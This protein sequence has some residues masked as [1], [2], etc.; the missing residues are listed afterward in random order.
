MPNESRPSFPLVHPQRRIWFGELMYPGTG[1]ANITMTYRLDCRPDAALL[2][3]AVRSLV[4]RHDGL[5]LEIVDTGGAGDMFARLEQRARPAESMPVAIVDARAW[6]DE[7][8]RRWADA[9]AVVPFRLLESPLAEFS[10]LDCRDGAVLVAKLHHVLSDGRTAVVVGQEIRDY[11]ERRLA[12]KPG[13]DPDAPPLPSYFSFVEPEQRYLASPEAEAQ[14]HAWLE[15]FETLPEPGEFPPP[16]VRD[17]G[18]AC[19]RLALDVPAALTRATAAFCQERKTSPFKV[20]LAAAAVHFARVMGTTDLVFGMAHHGRRAESL[21]IAGMF[22]DTVPVRVRVDL[23]GTFADVVTAVSASMKRDL[24][25]ARPYPYDLLVEDLRARHPGFGGLFNVNVV[26]VSLPGLDR[27]RREF[28]FPAAGPD[29]LSLQVNLLA[30][31]CA[32]LERLAVDTQ[33]SRFT[34]AETAA[35]GERMLALI[36]DALARPDVPLRTLAVMPAVERTLVLETFNTTRQDLVASDATVISLFA[37]RVAQQPEAL[38]LVAGDEQLT[39]AELDRQSTVL[40]RKLR[41]L[42]VGADTVVG[43]LTSRTAD[44][45]RAPLSVLKAGGAYVPMDPAYPSDRLRYFL[46]NSSA[47]VLLAEPDLIQKVEG[48]EGAI[49]RLGDPGLYVDDDTDGSWD[50]GLAPREPLPLPKPSDLAYVIYT[51]GSTGKPKGV[52]V[53]HRSLSNFAASIGSYYGLVPADRVTH[54]FGFSFDAAVWTTM[55]PLVAGATIVVV[56]EAIRPSPRQLHDFFEAN[57]ITVVGLPTQL[58]EQFLALPP[59]R[60][61]RVVY[62]GGDRFRQYHETPYRVVNEYGPTENTVSSTRYDVTGPS[63]NIPIGRP[64]PNTRTYVLDASLEPL[65]VGAVGELCVAGAQVARGYLGR[66]D[67][68]DERFVA[69]PFVPGDRMYR[70]G[71]L[72]RWKADGNIEFIGRRDAQVKIRGYRIETGEIEQVLV[73]HPAVADAAVVARVDE[74]GFGYLC[75]YV[76]TRA[77]VTDD[78]IRAY[79]GQEL[80]DY[81]VPSFL[82]RMPSLPLTPNGKVDRKALPA[83]ETGAGRT[84][85]YAPPGTPVEEKLIAIWESVLGVRPIGI[86]ENFFTLGGH[87]LKAALV[88]ARIADEL[89][90]TVPLAE[91]FRLPS[92]AQLAPAVAALAVSTTPTIQSGPPQERTPLAPAQA[93]LFA[94]GQLGD[95]GTAYNI[96]IANLIHGDIDADRFEAALRLVVGRHDAFKVAF[97]DDGGQ[98]VMVRHADV[99]FALERLERGADADPQSVARS[100][101]APFD[102]SRA[103]LARA[104]LVRLGPGKSLFLFEAHHLVFDGVSAVHLFEEL[105]AAYAGRELPPVKLSYLDF[106]AWEK[107]QAA[108]PRRDAQRAFWL[109]QLGGSLPVLELPTDRPRP[110]EK[111]Y[112]GARLRV[113]SDEPLMRGLEGLASS[114]GATLHQLLLSAF[115]TWLFRHGASDDVVIGTPVAGRLQPGLEH[116]IGMFVNTLPLRVRPEADKTFRALV[117]ETR[118]LAVAALDRQEVPFRE[119]VSHLK[120]VRDPGRNPLYDV[121]FAWQNA[122][123]ASFEGPGFRMES[124]LLETGTAQLDLSLDASPKDGRLELVFEYSTALFREETIRRWAEHL[125]VLLASVVRNPDTTVASLEML[126][127]VELAGLLEGDVPSEPGPGASAAAYEL[128]ADTLHGA[129]RQVAWLFPARPALTFRELELDYATLDR[130]TDRLAARLVQ[131]GLAPGR[132]G[133]LLFQRNAGFVVAALAVMKAG[134]AYL[135]IDPDYPSDRIA[136]LLEDSGAAVLLTEPSLDPRAPGFAGERLHVTVERLLDELAAAPDSE[137]FAETATAADAAYVIY[138]SGS[139]G[140]PKGVVIEHRNILNLCAWHHA[141]HGVTEFDKSAAYSGFGFDASVWEIFPFLVRG[142]EVRVLPEDIRLSIDELNDTFIRGGITITNL[143]TQ[144][145]EQFVESIES[146]SLRTLVTGGDALRRFRPR[147]Y[148]LVN[149]YGPTECTIS[150]TACVVTPEM[151]SGGSI[152]IGRPLRKTWAYVVGPGGS[153]QPDGVPGELCL[154]GA[155][156]ARGYLGRPELTAERFIENPFS[157]GP[158][159]TRLYRTGDRVRRLP[160]RNIEYLGRLDQQVKIRGFRIELGEIEQRVLAH[161]SVSSAVVLDVDDGRGGKAL[162]AYCVTRGDWDEESLREHIGQTLPA[163]M[164]PASFVRLDAIPLTPN[165]KIDRRALPAPAPRSLEDGARF[166]APRGEREVQLASAFRHVLGTREPGALDDFFSLG[167][168]SI[169]AIR[170]ASHLLSL[171]VK[172][173]VRDLFKHPTIRAL[174]PLLTAAG[175]ARAMATDESGKEAPLAPIQRWLFS[176][177]PSAQGRVDQS[178]WLVARQGLDDE[179]TRRAL[180]AVVAHHDALR[181]VFAEGPSGMVQRVRPAGEGTL[182]DFVV[183]AI[184]TDDEMPKQ[185]AAVADQLHARADLAKGPL[186]RAALVHAPG[187][188]HLVIVIHHLVVDGVS[189]RILTEDL[190]TAYLALDGARATSGDGAGVAFPAKTWSFAAWARALVVAATDG[191]LLAEVPYWSRVEGLDVPALP[192]DAPVPA[193]ERTA[194]FASR[195]SVTLPASD[196]APLLTTAHAAY[197]TRVNDLLLSGLALAVRRWASVDRVALQMEG[198]GREAVVPG[199]DISRTVGWFTSVFPLVLDTSRADADDIGRIVRTVKE[200]LRRLPRNGVGAGILRDLTPGDRKPGLVH[201]LVPS[202]G[203]NYLGQF[204]EASRA[205][206]DGAPF[207]IAALTVGQDVGPDLPAEVPIDIGAHVLGGALTIGFTYDSR[208][209]LTPSIERFAQAFLDA[210][211]DVAAHCAA[212]TTPVRT[213]SDVGDASL[214]EEELAALGPLDEVE[215][216]YALAPMQEGM[217]LSALR[218]PSSSAYFEQSY[219]RVLGPLEP[220]RLREALARTIE[221]HAA[222]RTVVVTRGLDRPRQVVRRRMTSVLDLVDVSGASSLE[223]EKALRETAAADVARGFDLETGPLARLTVLRVGPSEHDVILSLHHIIVDG[224]C[225]GLLGRELFGDLA[226]LHGVGGVCAAGAAVIAPGAAPAYRNYVDWVARQDRPAAT[227]YWTDLLSGYE[228]R[229]GIPR[230]RS[231]RD[232]A[233]RVLTT[234]HAELPASLVTGLTHLA[235][236]RHATLGALL[237]A[238]WGLLLMRYADTEDAV[239][240]SV[241][242]GRPPDLPG[243]DQTIGLFINTVPVRVAGAA[244]LPFE[245]LLSRVQDQIVKSERQAFVPLAD[246]QSCSDLGNGLFEHILAFESF[247]GGGDDASGPFSVEVVGGYDYSESDFAVILAPGDTLK[248]RIVY[249]AAVHDRRVVE[250]IPGHLRRVLESVSS[251]PDVPLREIDLLTP[252]ERTL[253]LTR[254]SIGKLGAI[255]AGRKTNVRQLRAVLPQ[256]R[257]V[258][259]ADDEDDAVIDFTPAQYAEEALAQVLGLTSPADE[260]CAVLIDGS[261]DLA[262]LGGAIDALCVRHDMLRARVTDAGVTVEARPRW[263][264]VLRNAD[265]STVE[266][267]VAA[268]REASARQGSGDDTRGGAI[269]LVRLGGDR[270]LLL[271][272]VSPLLVDTTSFEIL[273]SELAVLLNGEGLSDPVRFGDYASWL[274]D[275]LTSGTLSEDRLYWLG[276][277]STPASSPDLPLDRPRPVSRRGLTASVPVPLADEA[278]RALSGTSG[279]VAGMGS[280]A[281]QDLFLSSLAAVLAAHGRRTDIRLGL[282]LD[283]RVLAGLERAVGRFETTLPLRLLIDLDGDALA[284][285]DGISAARHEATAHAAYPTELLA[286][287]LA[288]PVVPGRGPLFDVVL[289]VEDVEQAVLVGPDVDRARSEGSS[290][291]RRQAVLRRVPVLPQVARADLTLRVQTGSDGVAASLEYSLDVF[292]AA[293]I[294]ALAG[295]VARAVAWMVSERGVNVR[296]LV[297][298]IRHEPPESVDGGVHP[299][300]IEHTVHSLVRGQ[301]RRFAERVAV[302]CGDTRLTYRELDERTDRL[303]ARLRAEGVGRGQFVA[304]MVRRSVDHIIGTLAVIKAGGAFLPLD[305]EYPDERIRMM[306]EDSGTRVFLGQAPLRSRTSWF[307]GTWLDLADPAWGSGPV[308]DVPDLNA[309]GDLAYVI[310][311]SG[312]TGKPKGAMISH[313]NLANICVDYATFYELGFADRV[314]LYVGLGFD[315]S[316]LGIF[317]P[318]VAGAEVVV[319]PSELRLSPDEL[320]RAFEANGVTHATLPT[321]FCEQFVATVDCPTL[322]TIE[323]GGEALRTYRPRSYKLVNAYGPTEAT[324]ESTRFVVDRQYDSIPIG[325]PVANT[326]LHVVDRYRRLQPPGIPGELCIAG[327]GLGQGYLGRPELTAEKFVPNPWT[328]R[329]MNR[330]MYRTGDLVRWLPDGQLEFL[331]RIDQQVKIRGFRIELGEIEQRLL[332]Q[333]SVGEALVQALDEPRGGKELCAWV[334]PRDP[335]QPPEPATIRTALGR[336]LPDYMVPPSILVLPSFPVT[337]NGKVDRKALPRPARV[338]TTFAPPQGEDEKAIAAVFSEVLGVP[339]VGRDDSFFAL[340]GHSIKAVAATAAVAAPVRRVGQRPVRASDGRWSRGRAGAARRVAGGA[341]GVAART[342]GRIGR[343]RRLDRRGGQTGGP[344]G[345]R[346]GDARGR[347]DRPFGE[348]GVA[349][350]AVDRRHRASRNPSSGSAATVR[351]GRV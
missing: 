70:T 329:E 328:D 124:M 18:I 220:E 188:D 152:P 230:I 266:Q 269:E 214:S 303:A 235:R 86:H 340:G 210:L 28:H 347:G 103:P 284:L 145:A 107:E 187:G 24:S 31:K 41:D 134:A 76:V 10:V 93:G 293:T 122:G 43:I 330:L 227:R 167:G 302:S 14:R 321:Q 200:T 42:G 202:I 97:A 75:G 312:S 160:D 6:D 216:V 50:D 183:V 250:A 149:E 155:Q 212:V 348:G 144:L 213:G 322:R 115:A 90:V 190:A 241:V 111:G 25:D 77:V 165:G 208:E 306:V 89:G 243:A 47:P 310:Y 249:D 199:A 283:G 108:A 313:R 174:A 2:A 135:P 5:R 264:R 215:A 120:V 1:F 110:K 338:A 334:T 257:A 277:H 128:T 113:V 80:P 186:V 324:V 246:I 67:L 296:E 197:G 173:D 147:P 58:A 280:A 219:Y 74:R 92:V 91:M 252:E 178:T 46:S 132:I 273:V 193:N 299:E 290:R 263:R 98:P 171:G 101:V 301:A 137:P 211:R 142:C 35:L 258:D 94:L 218:T 15:R 327:A 39:Y 195:F 291:S 179:R 325:R 204:D 201:R 45:V 346:L 52:M 20:V 51:S 150:A 56:P 189:W 289:A 259:A 9:Q 33:I 229:V 305:P 100:L 78:A 88:Q 73:R 130:I 247:P 158:E 4:T 139:T 232:G 11:C 185:L 69:D 182:V 126:P 81:M 209:M 239:F 83:P 342:A 8:V 116:V 22:V 288:I 66:P 223:R 181:L 34:E 316:I 278:V 267:L 265:G 311:T 253:L 146:T 140:R 271:L 168:D 156:V 180:E 262:R 166:E 314:A 238:A 141:F 335:N 207:H 104:T 318:L 237:H 170:L 72:A 71:D 57:A 233:E 304:V 99:K 23:D 82:T 95:L 153:L 131:Q 226:A 326:W 177:P 244:D 68:T 191:E 297:A 16:A 12:G 319:V 275:A 136:F 231:Q 96:P 300:R 117:A 274:D 285:M 222:L 54:F 242:S 85:A 198:H 350:R 49:L 245:A 254:F 194:A 248:V 133:A 298:A 13:V 332:E 176:L 64:N 114:L 331:G 268:F 309:P 112:E 333:E 63:E 256:R 295:D 236:S 276:L 154:A 205:P 282:R 102:L 344:I 29:P 175:A 17:T 127:A 87:S 317:P 336:H 121:L 161:P 106:A 138:T 55:P 320:G 44:I 21:P 37:E 323:T 281:T 59:C 261:V 192:V 169:Q 225:M 151:A 164:V 228:T 129:F 240:G 307:E 36:G 287:D 308:P 260:V 125:L 196:T 221:R 351:S 105:A 62:M 32:G 251:Q 217:L 337:A 343:G 349:A 38:A 157:T 118:D 26:D 270:S 315:A 65:P 255:H 206:D 294:A 203:F 84:V 292:D 48:Y 61:V 143:P 163:Y 30:G 27:M 53:E 3:E 7:E 279:S 40:A 184:E 159:N 339:E 224:W 162:C 234:L 172:L 109:E 79:L 148:R 123:G 60:G 341:T 119:I 345:L 272:A 19:R 286:R